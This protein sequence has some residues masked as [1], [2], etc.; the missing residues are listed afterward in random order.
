MGEKG[1]GDR[2]RGAVPAGL[3]GT[4]TCPPDPTPAPPGG[5]WPPAWAPPCTPQQPVVVGELL[6][7]SGVT[8][9]TVSHGRL[10]TARSGVGTEVHL[11]PIGR[12]DLGGGWVGGAGPAARQLAAP[13]PPGGGAAPPL[14]FGR[15]SVSGQSR[16]GSSAH[17]QPLRSRQRVPAVGVSPGCEDGDRGLGVSKGERRHRGAGSAQRPRLCL[18]TSGPRAILEAFL[19]EAR[20]QFERIT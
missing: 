16:L 4:A 10:V 2:A 13:S 7:R 14:P 11:V 5:D 20:F 18:G 19:K 12:G 15:A 3:L 6:A 1:A 17:P 8:C 9:R